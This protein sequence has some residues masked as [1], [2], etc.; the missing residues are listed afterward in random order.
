MKTDRRGM[1]PT[2]EPTLAQKIRAMSNAS[3]AETPRPRLPSMREY[4][5]VPESKPLSSRGLPCIVRA[6]AEI[7]FADGVRTVDDVYVEPVQKVTDG[8]PE[9][10]KFQAVMDRVMRHVEEGIVRTTFDDMVKEH[11]RQ[12]G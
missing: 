2:S 5:G 11:L 3:A 8:A 4:I 12:W 1:T 6:M 10:H 9:R 7:Q